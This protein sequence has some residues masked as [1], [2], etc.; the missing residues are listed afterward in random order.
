MFCHSSVTFWHLIW[1][2]PLIHESVKRANFSFLYYFLHKSW[3]LKPCKSNNCACFVFQ[4]TNSL[5]SNFLKN[6]QDKHQFVEEC[7]SRVWC[8]HWSYLNFPEVKICS[9]NIVLCFYSQHKILL[10]LT[11]I[12]HISDKLVWEGLSPSWLCVWCRTAAVLHI[13]NHTRVSVSMF[14]PHGRRVSSRGRKKKQSG[15]RREA[16]IT[17]MSWMSLFHDP[18]AS[19][20]FT[21]HKHKAY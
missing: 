19:A 8:F 5:L 7:E 12:Q 4:W 17:W 11:F 6:F 20:H 9:Q 3:L 10:R 16:I 14:F 2:I 15:G 1:V 18:P 21:F 13:Y